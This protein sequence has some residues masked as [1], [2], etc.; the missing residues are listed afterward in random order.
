MKKNG[1]TLIELIGVIIILGIVLLI[2]NPIVKNITT[3]NKEQ[4]YKVQISNIRSGLQNWAI[5]NSGLL[6]EREG[7]ILTVT[8]GKLKAGGYVDTELKNPKTNKC[9][10]NDMVLTIQRYQ[11]NYIYTVDET[12][13]TETSTCS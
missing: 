10:G 5:D 11:K 12:T 4:L 7:E 2:V 6:P 1:F 9:F 13:G 8:L 3:S